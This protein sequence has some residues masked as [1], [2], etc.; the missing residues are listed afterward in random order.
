MKGSLLAPV[1]I[2]S[3]CNGLPVAKFS[4]QFCDTDRQC[5]FCW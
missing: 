3:M 5:R 1:V 4:T 2:T